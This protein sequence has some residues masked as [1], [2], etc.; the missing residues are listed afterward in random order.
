MAG[1]SGRALKSGYA[2]NKYR[3]NKVRSYRKGIGEHIGDTA[4]TIKD[5]ASKTESMF[6]SMSNTLTSGLSNLESA[7]S[8]GWLPR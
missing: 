8:K 4:N 1:I 6:S 3:Y 2:K 5:G 7:L